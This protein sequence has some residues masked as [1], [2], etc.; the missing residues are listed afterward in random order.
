MLKI[1]FFMI[2]SW[3]TGNGQAGI[4]VGPDLGSR[5]IAAHHRGLALD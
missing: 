3:W 1:P 4:G 5:L 2:S